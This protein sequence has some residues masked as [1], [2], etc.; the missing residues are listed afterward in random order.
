MNQYIPFLSKSRFIKGIQCHKALWLQTHRPELKD[1]IGDDTQA[2]FDAGHNVGRLAQQMFPGGIEVPFD[3]VPLAE[4]I[5]M[6]RSLID[7]GTETI[8]ESAF[9]FDNVFIKADLLTKCATGWHLGEVKS[10]TE[11]KEHYMGL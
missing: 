10:S 8:F 1:A 7:S 5:Q 6:T 2:I 4:Q 9:S 11:A 3:N